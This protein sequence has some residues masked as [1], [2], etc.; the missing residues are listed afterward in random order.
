M[1]ISNSRQNNVRGIKFE[2]TSSGGNDGYNFGNQAA[3]KIINTDDVIID[4]C[5]FSHTG[6]IGLY[7]RNSSRVIIQN[8]I[9]FDIGYHLF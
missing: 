1:Q 3:V 5:E 7:L 4:N 9:F 2:H 6:M 8:N